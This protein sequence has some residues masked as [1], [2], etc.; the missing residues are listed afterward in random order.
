MLD[1]VGQG[2]SER[3]KYPP[4]DAAKIVY[5]KRMPSCCSLPAQR[6]QQQPAVYIQD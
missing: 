4:I 1:V 6:D 2:Q 3:T 5:S